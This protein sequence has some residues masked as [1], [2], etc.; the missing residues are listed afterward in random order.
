[1]DWQFA[2]SCLGKIVGY[3]GELRFIRNPRDR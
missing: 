1:M 3:G 2:L